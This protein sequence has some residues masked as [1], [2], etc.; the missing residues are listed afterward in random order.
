MSL[1]IL[2]RARVYGSDKGN[3]MNI[4]QKLAQIQQEIRCP[5][6]LENTFGGYKYRSAETI[7]ESLKPIMAKHKVMLLLIDDIKQIGDRHYVMAEAKL[8]DL[9]EETSVSTYAFA[10]ESLER[11]KMDAA[12]L[13]GS[14]SSYARKYALNGL[15]LLD[16]VKDPDT[17]EFTKQQMD[18]PRQKAKGLSPQEVDMFTADLLQAGA[19]IQKIC[20]RYKVKNL[21]ELTADQANE[22]IALV[23]GN[24]NNRNS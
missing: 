21:S 14:A 22:I 10:R 2:N 11:P 19:N 5:K 8:I 4:Y 13:T 24:G 17:N 3:A 7:L 23:R 6:N 15:L 12:Q 1:H 20:Q 18:K 16:D 9:E